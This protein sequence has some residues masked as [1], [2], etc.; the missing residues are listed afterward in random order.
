MAATNAMKHNV[1]LTSIVIKSQSTIVTN[2]LETFLTFVAI[3]GLDSS[4]NM[5][6]NVRDRALSRKIVCCLIVALC[7]PDI[8]KEYEPWHVGPANVALWQV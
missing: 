7:F 2:D 6:Y 3:Y 5:A 4:G 8:S 1:I